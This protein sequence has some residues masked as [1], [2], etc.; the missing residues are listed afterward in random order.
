MCSLIDKYRT[1]KV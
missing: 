1:L